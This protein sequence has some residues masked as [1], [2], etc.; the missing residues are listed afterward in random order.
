MPYATGIRRRRTPLRRVLWA[1][2]AAC[3]LADCG[4]GVAAF[5]L[6]VE[7]RV[8]AQANQNSP[9]PVTLLAV[10]DK[11][12]FERLSEMSAK[13]WYEQR[14]QLRRDFPGGDAFTEWEWEFVP[15][16]TPP[17]AVVEIPRDA[18]ALVFANYRSPGPHRIRLGPHQRI[19]ISLGEEDLSVTTLEARESQR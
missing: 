18:N 7:V 11:K 3:A 12:L 4:G 14:Y 1:M 15:G 19:R 5:R 10:Y 6:L 8:A 13:Q 16:Y 17:P 9:I 2:L